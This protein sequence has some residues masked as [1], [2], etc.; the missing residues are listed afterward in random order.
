MVALVAGCSAPSAT[1]LRPEDSAAVRATQAAFVDAWLRDDTTG[2]LAL[3]DSG[4]VLLPP[5]GRALTGRDAVRDYWWPNDGSRTRITSFDWTAHEVA[6]AGPL[7]YMRGISTL[8]WT[9][10]K[11]TLHQTTTAHSQSLILLQRSAAGRWLIAR[12]MWAPTPA[13]VRAAP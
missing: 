1:S 8:T 5:G 13:P 10:D 2:V 3:L 4:V 11:D 9:Y 7:A 6:G 12:Q